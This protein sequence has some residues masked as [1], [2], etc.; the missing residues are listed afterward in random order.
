MMSPA[1]TGRPKEEKLSNTAARVVVVWLFTDRPGAELQ[2]CR[3]GFVWAMASGLE[4]EVSPD[5]AGSGGKRKRRGS[6]GFCTLR[7][8]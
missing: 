2:Y 5:L 3:A 1:P 6:G 8:R 4:K 7:G